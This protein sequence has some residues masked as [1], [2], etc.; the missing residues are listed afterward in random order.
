MNPD[1]GTLAADVPTARV[2]VPAVVGGED[3]G[4]AELVRRGADVEGTVLARAV[5]PLN[6]PGRSERR[7]RIVPRRRR[8]AQQLA[9]AAAR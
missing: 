9:E 5:R 8:V 4:V 3:V 6:L 7:D 2:V 1:Y